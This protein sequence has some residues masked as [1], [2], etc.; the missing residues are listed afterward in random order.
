MIQLD[1][2][3]IPKVLEQVRPQTLNFIL[4]KLKSIIIEQIKNPINK[5]NFNLQRSLK[6]CL[7]LTHFLL[8]DKANFEVILKKIKAEE[9]KTKEKEQ[10]YFDL[11]LLQSELTIPSNHEILNK[12]EYDKLIRTYLKWHLLFRNLLKIKYDAQ[13]KHLVKSDWKATPAKYLILLE[14][15]IDWLY[16]LPSKAIFLK[17]IETKLNQANK[18]LN[19]FW[20][21]RTFDLSSIKKNY[22]W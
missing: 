3:S 5:D 14:L 22:L 16:R 13:I 6:C 17:A 8:K 4:K 20:D 2:S 15:I 18:N 10:L 7:L 9:L 12:L 19:H 21:L 11:L 1:I